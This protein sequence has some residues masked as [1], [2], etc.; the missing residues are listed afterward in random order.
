MSPEQQSA[1]E[2]ILG[3][4][5]NQSERDSVAPLLDYE[6]RQDVEI[7]ALLSSMRAP[8]IVSRMIG[9]GTVL[10]CMA[11]EGGEFLNLLEELSSVDANVKWALRLID[12]GNLD[13]GLPVTREQ[14]ITYK[15]SMPQL[16]EGITKL[17]AEAEVPDVVDFNKVSDALN[18]AEG[19]VTL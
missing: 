8:R 11:P 4:Q 6:N 2:G 13:V 9:I 18:V 12:Q 3:R 19:R 16:A 14:F 5:M 1:L 10:A 15:D 7:A 17:L